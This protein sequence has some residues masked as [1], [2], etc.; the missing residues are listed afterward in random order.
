VWDAVSSSAFSTKEQRTS[1]AFGGEGRIGPR[2]SRP[3]CHCRV[4]RISTAPAMRVEIL[5]AGSSWRSATRP[6]ESPRSLRRVPAERTAVPF[7]V[8]S[9]RSAPRMVRF[10]GP[11]P[12]WRRV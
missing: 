7:A 2:S 9:G 5:P 10:P 1:S 3:G 12:A 11:S 6:R 4:A 8:L